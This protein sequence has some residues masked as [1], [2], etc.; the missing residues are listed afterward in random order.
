MTQKKIEEIRG[1]VKS[2]WYPASTKSQ[3]SNF[4]IV[5]IVGPDKD[6]H[7][8]KGKAEEGTFAP[9]LDFSFQGYWKDDDRYG[10]GFHFE[11]FSH[12]EP[13]TYKGLIGYFSK[14]LE[15]VGPVAAK[16]LVDEFGE[17]DVLH[18][19]KTD[20]DSVS[21]LTR[22]TFDQARAAA[23]T[24]RD[25]EDMEETNIRL[26]EIL[27]GRGFPEKIYLWATK[28]W[29]IG[30]VDIIKK[31]PFRLLIEGAPGAGFLRCDLM[32]IEFAHDPNDI[33]RQ[34]FGLWA[35]FDKDMT[36]HT[37]F[38][39]SGGTA[40]LRDKLS[41][42]TAIKTDEALEY[43]IKEGWLA[44]RELNGETHITS[45]ER[46]MDEAVILSNLEILNGD[47]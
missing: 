20:P 7:E 31:N 39:K 41:S 15:G 47:F 22:L 6:I 12:R 2:V 45:Q 43:G 18:I 28:R 21:L 26:G 38:P 36:G 19:M 17:R 34:M 30:C 27:K 11:Q 24:L 37:W 4:C 40:Y 9:N 5:K 25:M 35:Y 42:V 29:G 1:T 13:L 44:K 16:Q 23:A 32:W 46:A 33:Q 10:R 14:Y 8:C 3:G